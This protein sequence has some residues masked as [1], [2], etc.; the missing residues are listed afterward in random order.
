M[1]TRKV[2]AI[3]VILIVVIILFFVFSP[4]FSKKNIPMLP[5]PTPGV[6]QQLEEKFRGLV[7]PDDIKK[8]E[9]KNVSDEEGMGIATSS[10]AVADLPVLSPGQTYQVLLGNGIKTILLG[11][12][13]Q[14]KGGF[15]LEYD[16]SKYPGYKQIFITKGSQHILEGTFN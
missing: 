8:I 16:L 3:L 13:K 15:L 6:E 12:M 1:K 9:L 4:K 11:N 2:V 10:E 14:A 5:N 7:I